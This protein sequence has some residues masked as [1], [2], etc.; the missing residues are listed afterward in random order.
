[1]EAINWQAV[2][3]I[4][5]SLGSILVIGSLIFLGL[6]IRNSAK[7]TKAA[8]MN[9]MSGPDRPHENGPG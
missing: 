6:E 9:K 8:T 4:S 7:V 3:A 1:M 2:H 5:A